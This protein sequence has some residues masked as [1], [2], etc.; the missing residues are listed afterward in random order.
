MV[1]MVMFGIVCFDGE[2][3]VVWRPADLQ[4]PANSYP[5]GPTLPQHEA[6]IIARWLSAAQADL[7]RVFRPAFWIE[8]AP[9]RG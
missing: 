9:D 3:Q 1:S 2:C 7:A 4:S 5:I 6:E 8:S